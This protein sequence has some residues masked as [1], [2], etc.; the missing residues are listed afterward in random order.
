MEVVDERERRREEE[1]AEKL[2]IRRAANTK[3]IVVEEG[4]T[5]WCSSQVGTN[6][7]VCK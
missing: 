5:A 4:A 7:N 3:K 6:L 2:E 1:E